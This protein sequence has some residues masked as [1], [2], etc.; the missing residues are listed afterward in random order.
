VSVPVGISA[1]VPSLFVVDSMTPSVNVDLVMSW[2]E[3]NPEVISVTVKVDYKETEN[4]SVDSLLES[5]M[6]ASDVVSDSVLMATISL[7]RVDGVVSDSVVVYAAF[8]FVVTSP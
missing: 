6:I 7:V 8:P 2:V 1:S 5:L 3:D 4:G